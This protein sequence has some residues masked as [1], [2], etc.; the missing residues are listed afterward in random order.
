[1]V[2]AAIAHRPARSGPAGL[3][4][5][6]VFVA[7]PY[8][9]AFALQHARIDGEADWAASAAQLFPHPWWAA[10][11]RPLRPVELAGR[12]AGSTGQIPPDL[13]RAS[14]RAAWPPPCCRT[15]LDGNPR[16]ATRLSQLLTSS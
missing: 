8:G 13:R 7:V 14:A 4:N 12:P 9:L 16:P 11:R 10:A 1:M 2:L 3:L 5:L 15:E 6:V